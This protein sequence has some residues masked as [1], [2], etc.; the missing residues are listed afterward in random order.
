MPLHRRLPVMTF[1]A[2]ALI[3]VLTSLVYLASDYV[4]FRHQMIHRLSAIAQIIGINS[5]AAL[6]FDDKQVAEQLLTSLRNEDAVLCAALYDKQGVLF[7]GYVPSEEGQ[8]LFA[9]DRSVEH[10][11]LAPDILMVEEPVVL[12][13]RTTGHIQ[14]FASRQPLTDRLCSY[15]LFVA[16]VTSALAV[17]AIFFSRAI[18]AR[19]VRPL[20]ALTNTAKRISRDHDYSV[21]VDVANTGDVSELVAAF[22]GMLERIHQS[23]TELTA[24]QAKLVRHQQRLSLLSQSLQTAEEHERRELAAALHDSVCQ[25]LFA[26][27]LQ[28]AALAR[29]TRDASQLPA[30]LASLRAGVQTAIREARSITTRLA[31]QGIYDLGLAEALRCTAADTSESRGF[32]VHVE[33]LSPGSELAPD[34]RILAYRCVQELLRNAVKHADA[35][36]VNI[37]ISETDSGLDIVVCDDGKGFEPAEA[38][39][40]HPLDRGFGLFSVVERLRYAGGSVDVDSSP[41]SGACITLQ[42]PFEEC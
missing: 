5:T 13:G 11:V 32:E 10:G 16:L 21:R 38:L 3:L 6:S 7:A 27:E 25:T 31:P 12:D 36:H 2:C 34:M 28:L 17:I 39:S 22:N 26:I 37:T 4:S 23:K 20:E 29:G 1:S 9:A 42:F 41:G 33:D 40:E 14:I 19:I 35:S 8:E 18:F 24:N 15:A 30:E